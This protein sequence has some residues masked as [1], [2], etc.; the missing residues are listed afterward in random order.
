MG[1]GPGPLPRPHWPSLPGWTGPT[2]E[3]SGTPGSTA[4]KRSV[5]VP[6]AGLTREVG[7]QQPV[8]RGSWERP[9]AGLVR[10]THFAG[11]GLFSPPRTSGL[12]GGQSAAVC[13]HGLCDNPPPTERCEEGPGGSRRRTEPGLVTDSLPR[14]SVGVGGWHRS[15]VWPGSRQAFHEEMSVSR[16][17]RTSTEWCSL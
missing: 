5:S 11:V 10:V 17:N 12:C 8:P 14:Q 2:R 7:Q 15:P 16:G 3:G 13:F 6:S 4:V 9:A 1:S